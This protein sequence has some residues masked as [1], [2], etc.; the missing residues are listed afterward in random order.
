MTCRAHCCA[1][2]GLFDRRVAQRD[3]KRYRRK[4]PSPSTRRLLSSTRLAGIVGETV[5]DIGGGIG[6]VAQELLDAGAARATLVE[7]SAAYLSAAR[8]EVERR[9][10]SARL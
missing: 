8:D 2:D 5:L 1:I 3:L 6:A 7:A 4:G 9:D 10:T